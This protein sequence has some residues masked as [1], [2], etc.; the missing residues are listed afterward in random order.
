MTYRRLIPVLCVFVLISLVLALLS[1]SANIDWSRLV[2]SIRTG[3][4]GIDYT[5]VFN[6][7]LPRATNAFLV[8]GML[9]L[10]G[11]L[12]QVLLRNPLADPYVLGV[13]GGAAVGALIALLLGFGQGVLP[14]SAGFGALVS[15]LLV[16]TLARGAADWS[17][18]RL[19]LTGIVL[20]AGWGAIV[21]FILSVSPDAH[22]RGMLFWLMGDISVTPAGYWRPVLLLLSLVVTFTFARSLNLLTHGELR[23]ES[24]GVDTVQVRIGVYFLA[25]AL[26][27][28]AVTLAGSV[29]FVGLIVPH[30]VRLIAGG[31]HRGLLISAT[32]LGGVLLVMAD[33]LA[34]TV[35]APQQL[36]VGVITAFIGVPVFLYLLSRGARRGSV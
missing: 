27:A 2:N 16:F 21:S 24:L 6:L 13:S 31:D 28:G 4:A 10:A 3:E 15:I 1:G 33:T 20:A 26:T 22:L 36:P 14:F 32:L 11:V 12:M 23:A 19:L 29:G 30:M 18:V 35:V 8:G 9:A 5:V 7:R 25:A 17:P 34:R